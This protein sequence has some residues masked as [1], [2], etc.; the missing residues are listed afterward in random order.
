MAHQDHSGD[1]AIDDDERSAGDRRGHHEPHPRVS[2]ELLRQSGDLERPVPLAPRGRQFVPGPHEPS[3][4]DQGE[5]EPSHEVAVPG[6]AHAWHQEKPPT[7]DRDCRGDYDAV[8][9]CLLHAAPLSGLS[10]FDRATTCSWQDI[11]R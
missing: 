11:R 6:R 3:E 8:Q 2:R 5:E 4:A 9:S 1:G 7:E 10:S